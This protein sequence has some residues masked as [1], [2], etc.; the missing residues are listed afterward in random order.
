MPSAKP[1]SES[2]E[3]LQPVHG[4]KEE[5]PLDTPVQGSTPCVTPHKAPPPSLQQPPPPP[6]KK[7]PS[8]PSP[9]PP[10]KSVFPPARPNDHDLAMPISGSGSPR[11]EPLGQRP[12]GGPWTSYDG[13]WWLNYY[14]SHGGE[15]PPQATR[16]DP[17]HW[18]YSIVSA[19][20]KG[21]RIAYHWKGELIPVAPSKPSAE[22]R[23]PSAKADDHRAQGDECRLGTQSQRHRPQRVR[24]AHEARRQPLSAFHAPRNRVAAIERHPSSTLMIGTSRAAGSHTAHGNQPAAAP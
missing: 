7:M 17:D 18:S 5:T 1:P 6:P 10:A 9:S 16:L 2:S 11:H 20:E 12:V 14:Y 23:T 22:A 15:I 13:S 19:F 4:E 21:Q 8:Q 3:E 24:Q